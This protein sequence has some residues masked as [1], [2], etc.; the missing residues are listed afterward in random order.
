LDLLADTYNY[1][2]W[3]YSL[4]R[5]YI[6]DRVLEVGAGIGNLTRFLLQCERVVCL[7]PD[8]NNIAALNQ[9]AQVHL[10]LKII[11]ATVET[12]SRRQLPSSGVDT[13]ICVNVLEHIEDD[14]YATRRMVSTL[15]KEGRLLLYVPACQWAYGVLDASLGH[16]RRYSKQRLYELAREVGV[17]LVMCRYINFVG[18]FGWWWTSRI[19]KE[20]YIDPQKARF[21]DRLVPFLSASERLV[22]PIVGQSLLAILVKG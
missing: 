1:N 5:P 13:V 3:V 17:R 2:H 4:L 22:K 20:T 9:L 21:L 14:T 10:N 16:L 18:L 11:G 15:R 19:S 8:R 6:G 12:F 7:E